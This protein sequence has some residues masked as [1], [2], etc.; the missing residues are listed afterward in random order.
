M[1]KRKLNS[2]SARLDLMEEWTDASGRTW[3]RGE[4][5]WVGKGQSPRFPGE[6]V[7]AWSKSKTSRHR[8]LHF[9][10]ASDGMVI[11]TVVYDAGGYRMIRSVD[12]ER[13]GKRRNQPMDY[14]LPPL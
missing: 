10:E 5:V 14:E 3:R 9:T 2:R 11:A 4:Y 6:S 1:V 7:R 8:I 13:L 12:A